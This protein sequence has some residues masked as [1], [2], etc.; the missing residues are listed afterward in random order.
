MTGKGNHER[1]GDEENDDRKGHIANA[2]DAGQLQEIAGAG[3]PNVGHQ[4]SHLGKDDGCPQDR[5]G[6][7]DSHCAGYTE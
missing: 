4:V 2:A 5:G 1:D 6:R 3:R 7:Q